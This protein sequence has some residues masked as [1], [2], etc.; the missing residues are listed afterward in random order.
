M[1]IQRSPRTGA[2][3]FR[4]RA[5]AFVSGLP[6]MEPM[7]SLAREGFER[8][9]VPYAQKTDYALR[10]AESDSC[11]AGEIHRMLKGLASE[12]AWQSGPVEGPYRSSAGQMGIPL[13]AQDALC[14]EFLQKSMAAA[15]AIR[16]M[17]GR[18]GSQE[19]RAALGRAHYNSTLEKGVLAYDLLKCGS[20][21][22]ERARRSLTRAFCLAG[23]E[24]LNGGPPSTRDAETM[25]DAIV[26]EYGMEG[27]RALL[28]NRISYY[29][30]SFVLAAVSRSL[31]GS[32]LSLP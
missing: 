14:R 19:D 16:S 12:R 25:L 20:I 4:D 3:G 26:K 9:G 23:I 11:G 31:C 21:T 7:V 18:A 29:E 15:E 8:E 10:I 28:P 1:V 17:R 2:F 5:R 27:I 13:P 32:D 24:L 30:A 22:S 6:A